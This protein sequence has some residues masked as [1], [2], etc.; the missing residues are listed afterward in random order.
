M[1]VVYILQSA[2]DGSLYAGI[3]TDVAR[4]LRQHNTGVGAKRTRGRGPWELRYCRGLAS[5]SLALKE[6]ARIKKLSRAKK[7]ALFED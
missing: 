7:L 1:W 2:S 3:T 5:K 6:E 4:R